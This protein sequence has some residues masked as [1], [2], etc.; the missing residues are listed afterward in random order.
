MDGDPASGSGRADPSEVDA[1]RRGPYRILSILTALRTLTIDV[2]IIA[3]V[4][5]ILWVTIS[6]LRGDQTVIE[7]IA[8]P[9][10]LTKMG[11]SGRVASLRLWDAMQRIIEET[12]ETTDFEETALLQTASEQLEI[13]EPE[14]GLSLRGLSQLVRKVLRIEQDR[15]A[16]DFV[17]ADLKCTPEQVTLRLRI[18]KDGRVHRIE[19]PP[20]GDARSEQEL[21]AYFEQAALDALRVV[22]PMLVAEYL[23]AKY[24]E[25]AEEAAEAV[26]GAD[27]E[28]GARA[29]TLL[30]QLHSSSGNMAEAYRWKERVAELAPADETYWSGIAA[31]TLGWSHKY[32]NSS[33]KA[34]ERFR[35]ALAIFKRARPR[36]PD[37]P[38]VHYW[39]GMALMGIEEHDLA[40]ASF[41]KFVD[42]EPDD[43]AGL[44]AWGWALY[45]R[46]EAHDAAEKYAQ[47]L[48]ISRFKE[49]IHLGWADALYRVRRYEE[50]IDHYE[51]AS[52]L[53]PELAEPYYGLGLSYLALMDVK[54]AA[55]NL[56]IYSNLTS[57]A[58]EDNWRAVLQEVVFGKG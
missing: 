43:P 52:H 19:T 40:S 28:H 22:D 6:D 21:S 44:T 38:L 9:E 23:N 16:G 39:T 58:L 37:K 14:S 13:T 34:E 42:L 41:E 5:G 46:G 54:R 45:E 1:Q 50:A 35:E 2:A 33:G 49:E 51:D 24:H 30:V 47:A 10:K 31:T 29:A 26:I 55:Q 56:R 36:R 11:Y 17:C 48:I 53:N 12:A 4:G 8:L 18:F 3:F 27:R 15:I 25:S 57:T 32:A 7:E 20:I